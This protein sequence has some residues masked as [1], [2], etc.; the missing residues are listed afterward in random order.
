M[1]ENPYRIVLAD[2]HAM[3]R[4]GLKL[5]IEMEEGMHVVG[6]AS[7]GKELLHVLALAP[8]DLV[9]LDLTMHGL[10]GIEVIQTVRKKF[11][12]VKILIYTHY[13]ELSTIH[14][15]LD[16][17]VQGYVYHGDDLEGIVPAVRVLQKNEIYISPM[18][19]KMLEGIDLK[20][21]KPEEI[22]HS[23]SEKEIALLKY[24]EDGLG[25]K[26]ISKKMDVSDEMVH[27]YKSHL[28]KKFNLENDVELV[29]FAVTH[30]LI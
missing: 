22:R 5:L 2:D 29:H 23:L 18:I 12:D 9:I 8:C 15:V 1:N 21:A 28:L 14:R 3:F 13:K 24:L 10:H 7:S 27:I 30:G 6:E 26:E 4:Y 25:T 19:Q 20:H 16:S 11:P 17:G